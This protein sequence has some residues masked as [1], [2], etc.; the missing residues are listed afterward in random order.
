MMKK[1]I[2]FI[3][4]IG[5]LVFILFQFKEEGRG[6]LV[7]GGVEVNDNGEIIKF[8]PVD[9]YINGEKV[10]K[11]KV[12]LNLPVG[13][14]TVSYGDL[15]G[16]IKPKDRVV[17]VIKDNT[18]YAYGI[19]ELP[20]YEVRIKEDKFETSQIK[21]PE[22]VNLIFSNLD[23]KA[24]LIGGY[25]TKLILPKETFKLRIENFTSIEFILDGN[26]DKK[27]KVMKD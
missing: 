26:S 14:Y 27:L 20:S 12:E 17:K 7:L 15:K 2:P 8:L 23:D 11:T 13:E 19:Y 6:N 25:F 18:L 1:I 22:K 5:L 21:V 4:I 10:G 24:H 3:F 9:I 16:Y